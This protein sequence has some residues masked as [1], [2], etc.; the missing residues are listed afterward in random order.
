MVR[1]GED[2]VEGR[3]STRYYFKHRWRQGPGHFH[4]DLINI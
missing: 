3:G 4:F 1:N 2:H